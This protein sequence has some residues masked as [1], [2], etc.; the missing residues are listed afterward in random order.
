MKGDFYQIDKINW[1]VMLC[2]TTQT[3]DALLI[4]RDS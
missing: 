2:P 1:S 3:E 4:G